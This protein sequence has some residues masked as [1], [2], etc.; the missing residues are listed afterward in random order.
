VPGRKRARARQPRPEV[1]RNAA[2]LYD[3]PM[4]EDMAE[5]M[6]TPAADAPTSAPTQAGKAAAAPGASTKTAGAAV[7]AGAPAQTGEAASAGAGAKTQPAVQ[8]TMDRIAVKTCLW[9][10]PAWIKPNHLTVL[11]LL[12]TPVILVLLYF[13]YRWWALAMFVVA[14]FTDFVDGAMARTRHQTST[15]GMYADPVADKLLVAAVLAWV[16]WRYLVVQIFL[17]FIVVELVFTAV[18][19]P[20]LLRSRSSQPSNVFG[21]AKMIAQSLALFLFLIAGILNLDTLTAVSL[22]LL[23]MALAL[24]VVSGGKQVFDALRKRWKEA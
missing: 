16:G 20:M 6:A 22:Y 23:W 12:F 5:G 9:A 15:F 13:E 18:G 11:R 1:D 4:A 2:T 14:T 17:A 21:K 10:I 7:A 8:R 24:A 3:A 19:V